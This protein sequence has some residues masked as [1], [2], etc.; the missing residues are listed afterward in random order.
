MIAVALVITILLQQGSENRV[1]LVTSGRAVDEDA[2][3]E[4]IVRHLAAHNPVGPQATIFFASFRKDKDVD[5]PDA[6]IKRFAPDK[7]SVKKV[8]ECHFDP[9]PIPKLN[10]DKD[11]AFAVY[12]IRDKK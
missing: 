8:S 11:T 10:I 4:V 7:I 5:P 1:P 6:F 2:I 12:G 9:K 3:R